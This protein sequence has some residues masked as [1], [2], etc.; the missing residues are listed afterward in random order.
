MEEAVHRSKCN[1]SRQQNRI[2]D[3][4]LHCPQSGVVYPSLELLYSTCFMVYRSRRAASKPPMK[5][6]CATLYLAC[7][8]PVLSFTGGLCRLGMHS[9][10]ATTG[11]YVGI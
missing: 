11:F 9:S 3:V 2:L 1:N 5:T 7:A 4:E 8:P 6:S 10:P